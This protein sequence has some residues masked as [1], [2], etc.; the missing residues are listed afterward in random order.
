M[1]PLMVIAVVLASLLIGL[2]LI[3][4]WVR[5]LRNE[6][7]A[8]LREAMEGEKVFRVED[9][10]FFG[11][12]SGGYLQIRGNGLLALTDRG[13]HF[14]MLLPRRHLFVPLEEIVS[15]SAARSFLGKSKGVRVL[16]VDFRDPVGSKD[17]CGWMVASVEWWME[18]LHSLMEGKGPPPAVRENGG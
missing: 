4:W 16:R 2:V 15:V 6:A 11:R 10:N 3:R 14:C 8:H 7:A 5:K 17:A 9:C 18:A 13:I 1:V 12:L